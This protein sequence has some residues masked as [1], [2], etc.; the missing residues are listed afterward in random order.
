[1]RL[2]RDSVPIRS[3]FSL[4][5]IVL[6]NLRANILN[7]REVR[8]AFRRLE[9]D[10]D[11]AV[12][13]LL[14]CDPKDLADR[15][16]RNFAPLKNLNGLTLDDLAVRDRLRE[17]ILLVTEDFRPTRDLLLGVP[18]W[19]LP[20]THATLVYLTCALREVTHAIAVDVPKHLRTAPA[21]SS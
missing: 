10:L 19:L 13:V 1:M 20:T 18:V 12:T 11:H 8:D 15:A 17:T 16:F 2:V 3:R 21:T 14:G 7:V 4:R 5:V 9:T 6:R